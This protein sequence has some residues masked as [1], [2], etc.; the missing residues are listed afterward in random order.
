MRQHLLNMLTMNKITLFPVSNNI[1]VQKQMLK[2]GD[3]PT[4][5]IKG[6]PKKLILPV[7]SDTIKRK[8]G[9]PKTSNIHKQLLPV[10]ESV[11]VP[12]EP[13]TDFQ[14]DIPTKKNRGRPK[15]L[16]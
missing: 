4:K 5:K 11:G 7:N 14:D 16:I 6:R 10:V 1:I 15:K 9:R 2:G 13:T 12:K 8:G 3:I